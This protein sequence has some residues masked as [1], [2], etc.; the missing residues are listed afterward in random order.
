ML[1]KCYVGIGNR[2]AD[3]RARMNSDILYRKVDNL[4][5]PDGYVT[6]MK[7]YFLAYNKHKILYFCSILPPP[8]ALVLYW[9]S[10]ASDGRDLVSLVYIIWLWFNALPFIFIYSSIC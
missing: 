3:L 9:D 1:Y 10:D 2:I 5:Q 7:I 6:M 4:M 8:D